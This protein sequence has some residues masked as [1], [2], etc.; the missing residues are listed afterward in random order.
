MAR[1]KTGFLSDGTDSDESG[2]AGDDAYNSQDDGD[3]RA[4]KALFEFNGKKRRR[5]E[6][7]GKSSAWEG[8]F[9]EQEESSG[10]G[11]GAGRGAHGGMSKRTDWTK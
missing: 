3:S 10:R 6:V 5:T 11:L 2:P 1:R 7:D 9:G 8:I 4:E